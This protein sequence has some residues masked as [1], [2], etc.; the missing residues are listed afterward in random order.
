[1][2]LA[3]FGFAAGCRRLSKFRQPFLPPQY[4]SSATFHSP[5]KVKNGQIGNLGK[6]RLRSLK[7]HHLRL[8]LG[9]RCGV[10]EILS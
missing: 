6:A 5:N 3:N 9:N 4:V 7:R 1:M 2:P 8:E 10:V